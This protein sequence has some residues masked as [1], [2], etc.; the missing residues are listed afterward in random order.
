MPPDTTV[1]EETFCPPSTDEDDNRQYLFVIRHGD[2]W[3]YSNPEWKKL[4]TSRL[5]DSPLSTLGH[6]QAREVGNFLDSWLA[7]RNLTAE[8]ITWLSSPFLRC[9]QTSN[10]ALNAFSRVDVMT[11]PILPEYSIFEWDGHNGEWH[12]DLP[13]LKE[14]KHY[15]PRLDLSYEGFFEPPMPGMC[16]CSSS[17]C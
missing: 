3:D 2:R 8:D 15:F 4:S 14:R 13:P 10:E 6:Q 12:K 17:W 7:D 16:L 9:L 11:T 5:G 1:D